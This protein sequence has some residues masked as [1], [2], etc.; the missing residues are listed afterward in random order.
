MSDKATRKRELARLRQQRR[1]EKLKQQCVTVT[2]TLTHEEAAQLD[3]LRS[4]RRMGRQPYTA[5]E[6]F[7][8][9]LIRDYQKWQEEKQQLGNCDFCGKSKAEG[10]CRGENKKLAAC[11]LQVDAIALNL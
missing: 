8:L 10:G 3:E 7:Q 1:R 6:Y 11:W 4:V 9:L 2:L 5:D